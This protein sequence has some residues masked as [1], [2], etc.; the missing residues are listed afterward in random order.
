MK[1]PD[2]Q[3]P[4]IDNERLVYKGRRFWII[5]LTTEKDSE[6]RNFSKEDG[7]YVF[8]DAKSQALYDEG[9]YAF[10]TKLKDGKFNVEPNFTH[11]DISYVA[12]ST[13]EIV[14]TLPKVIDDYLKTCT[15]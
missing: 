11:V 10:I 14:R 7:D 9:L 13:K 3:F 5:K 6:L 15:G 4:K 2:Y 1:M 8:Y 12:D